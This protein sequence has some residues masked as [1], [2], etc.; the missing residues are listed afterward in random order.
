V[1]RVDDL[2][3]TYGRT[4]AVQHVSLTV[5][6]GELVGLLGANGAGKSTT[7]LTIAGVLR[8]SHGS[9][10]FNGKD[11]GRRTPEALVR[12]GL[13]LV[14]EGRHIFGRLTV[15]ENLRLAAAAVSSRGGRG[16]DYD[17]VFS[18]FPVLQERLRGY[19]AKL[20]GGEQQQLAIARALLARPNLLLLDEPSLGLAPL[21]VDRVFETVERLRGDGATILLVEQNAAQALAISDRSYIMQSGRIKTAGASADLRESDDVATAYL[22][23]VR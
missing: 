20:S 15:E 17:R 4:A 22:G 2:V 5:E 14:P 7:L 10:V 21:L 8:A 3:V 23:A 18:L 9:I 11:I 1:L 6:R 16:A 12:D 19:A 13:V